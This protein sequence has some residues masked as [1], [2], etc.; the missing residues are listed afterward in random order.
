MKVIMMKELQEKSESYDRFHFTEK[1]YL[2]GIE[3]LKP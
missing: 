2:S 1:D 3:I